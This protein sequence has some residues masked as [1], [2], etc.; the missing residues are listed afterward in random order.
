MTSCTFRCS[1][2]TFNLR[3]GDVAQ[4]AER[5]V[6]NAEARSSNLLISTK[7][8]NGFRLGGGYFFCTSPRVRKGVTRN[9]SLPPSFTHGPCAQLR[10]PAVADWISGGRDTDDRPPVGQFTFRRFGHRFLRRLFVRRRRVEFHQLFRSSATPPRV[11]RVGRESPC[12]WL[13][14]LVTYQLAFTLPRKN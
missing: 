8:I 5:C 11:P 12:D 1:L 3:C 14:L 9:A 6:R 4:L 13:R 10:S 7:I 2:L